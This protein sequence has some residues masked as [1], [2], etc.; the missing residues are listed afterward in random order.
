[1]MNRIRL[2]LDNHMI[3]PAEFRPE[4]AAPGSVAFAIRFKSE[5]EARLFESEFA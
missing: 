2:W 3:E 5:D 4:V 1:M